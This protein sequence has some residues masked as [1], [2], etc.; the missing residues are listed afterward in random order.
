MLK[1]LISSL[2]AVTG[3][4]L[5]VFGVLSFLGMHV[6]A[7]G[8]VVAGGLA[9]LFS[10]KVEGGANLDTSAVVEELRAQID[11]LS[12]QAARDVVSLKAKLSQAE[13][14]INTLRSKV[15]I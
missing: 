12:T 7:Q 13:S 8:V 9:L 5:V 4:S 14:F 1:S 11:E 3:L 10:N 15:G 6:Y 2:P